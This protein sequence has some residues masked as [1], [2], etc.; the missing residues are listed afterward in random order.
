MSSNKGRSYAFRNDVLLLLHE[1]GFR[2]ATKPGEPR[3]LSP[4][5]K[6]R[7]DI[8]G[9]PVTTAV[10]CSKTLDLSNS[11]NEAQ[12][13]AEAEGNDVFVS[14]LARRS[15]PVEESFVV[16]SLDVWLSV[17]A[18]LHPEAVTS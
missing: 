7:G 5:D 2:S 9:L 8:L 3:G 12:R 14:I 13:E 15:H 17:L 11:L 1:H 6:V 4:N 16:T 10:R 18:R